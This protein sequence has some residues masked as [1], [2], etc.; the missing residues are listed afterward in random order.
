LEDD[1]GRYVIG[2]N[3]WSTEFLSIK[4]TEA[5]WVDPEKALEAIVASMSADARALWE[6]VEAAESLLEAERL[7]WK[8]VL[9]ADSNVDEEEA[10]AA[11]A[12]GDEKDTAAADATATNTR[13]EMLTRVRD[14][15]VEATAKELSPDIASELKRLVAL[16]G[17]EYEERRPPKLDLKP[18]QRYVL[19]RVF[20]LG[21]TVDRFGKFDR[22]YVHDD[23][24]SAHKAERIGKKYQWIALHE[25]LAYVSDQYRYREDHGNDVDSDRYVGPWQLN[26]RD[27]DPSLVLHAI[28]RGTGYRRARV[29]LVGFVDIQLEVRA[30]AR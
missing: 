12:V 3:S 27:I 7:P 9:R 16:L 15:A 6:Q 10:D 1:F 8:F 4:L 13:I 26:R 18:I 19:K 24:R 22:Y 5:P 17:G 30:V 21:W 2:T 25:I 29:M 23:G 28:P 11:S 20:D 14:E